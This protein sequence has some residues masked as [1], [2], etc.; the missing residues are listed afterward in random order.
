[1]NKYNIL[2]VHNTY[3][4]HGG[5]D[6]VVDDEI[7]LLRSHK[8]NILTYHRSNNDINN[9]NLILL[10]K[11]TIWSERT[12]Q[13]LIKIINK[14]NPNIIHAHNTFPLISPSLY[15]T[16]SHYKIP[17]IQT[18]HNFRL[19]CLNAMFLRNEKTCEDC[20]G[21]LP[22]R[23]V[24]RA[25]Y[26]GSFAASA[27]LAG[28]LAF[29][30]GIGTYRSKV[31]RFIAL[32]EF[33]RNK[34]ITGG[35]PAERIVV[36]P[37]FVDWDEPNPTHICSHDKSRKN[38]LFVGRMSAEKGIAILATAMQQLPEARLRVAG[39]GPDKDVFVGITGITRLGRLT[40]D[41]VRREMTSAMALIVPSICYENFPRT[42]VEAFASGLPVI[43]SR[44][45]P[46]ADIICEGK[47]GLLFV[48]GDAH[49][50]AAK[51]IWASTHPDEMR[52]MGAA[53][54]QEYERLYTP[55]RNYQMLM[56]IYRDAIA[57]VKDHAV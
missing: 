34:F 29:H 42:I 15:W 17:I 33:C 48:A 31:T 13:E 6:F 4:F 23:G 10:S 1:M 22:L 14:F 45:G 30:R 11:Q 38:F 55:E 40:E 46:L 12:K 16:A 43:A 21:Q 39:N 2:F 54:R 35:L 44:I 5:E 28:M 3:K 9:L 24:M 27:V 20:M 52:R 25:C 19:M 53:A 7:Y 8:H 49:D 32:N 56:D 47:T 50:L 57:E 18:L 41:S 36:K 37:N 26:R 51:M